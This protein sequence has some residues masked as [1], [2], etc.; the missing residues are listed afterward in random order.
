MYTNIVNQSLIANFVIAPNPQRQLRSVTAHAFVI[1]W[2]TNYAGFVLQENAALGTTNWVNST[3]AVSQMAGRR[4][5]GD[6]RSGGYEMFG[7]APGC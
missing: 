4:R 1:Q 2:P 5:V 3:N 6:R 7:L